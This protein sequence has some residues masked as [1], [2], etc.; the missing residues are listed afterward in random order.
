ME[1]VTGRNRAVTMNHAGLEL[2]LAECSIALAILTAGCEHRAPSRAVESEPS[3]AERA[4]EGVP[5][6][7]GASEGAPRAVGGGPSE[8]EIADSDVIRARCEHIARCGAIG[9]GSTYESVEA[10][11][12]A[13][14]EAAR[15]D[16]TPQSC[17][18]LRAGAAAECARSWRS[19]ACGATFDVLPQ[20]CRRAQMCE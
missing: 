16:V 4:V 10:C 15:D 11:L 14:R 2:T 19:L 3:A 8:L 13:P 18:Q 6:D 9:S 20:A 12:A 5:E 17:P 7:K 1:D